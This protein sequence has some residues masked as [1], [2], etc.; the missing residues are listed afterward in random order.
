M[1]TPERVKIIK[2]TTPVVGANAEKITRAF[3]PLMF[4]AHPELKEVFNQSHQRSGEQPAALAGAIVAYATHIDDLGVLSDALKTIIQKHVSLNIQPAQYE[5]VGTY[6]MKAIGEVLGDAVTPEIADAWG[7]AYW[8]L[9]NL[10]IAREEDEY[11]RKA[12]LTG[13]WRGARRMRLIAK[14][15]ESEVITSFVFAP[16]D[17]GPVMD[18]TPGQYVGIKFDVRG[19]IVHRN[20]SLS[21]APNGRTYRISV[22]KEKQGL[23]SS[24]LHED[25]VPGLEVDVYAPSGEFVLREGSAPIALITA[26]VGQTPALPMLETALR[27]NRPVTYIHAAINSATHAFKDH[28]NATAERS[29]LLKPVYVYSEPLPGDA[30]NHV[31]FVTQDILATYLPDPETEIYFLG[32]TPFMQIVRSSLRNLKVPDTKISFEFFGPVEALG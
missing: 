9:A 13:G 32:P 4:A 5:I 25:A 19:Q 23:V 16:V 2:A 28:I 21:A 1:L 20:Y 24:F 29:S 6:L 31:G 26:G 8:Q 30:P 11:T 27:G 7:A 22:K 15:K 10:L 3:Y 12:G 18:F 17:G 14:E